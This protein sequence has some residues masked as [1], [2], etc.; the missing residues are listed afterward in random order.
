M[1]W[2][3]TPAPC[4]GST[5]YAGWMK[6]EVYSRHNDCR[7][8]VPIASWSCWRIANGRVTATWLMCPQHMEMAKRDDVEFAD[9]DRRDGRTHVYLPLIVPAL[10]PDGTLDPHSESNTAVEC[11]LHRLLDLLYSAAR[12]TYEQ[13]RVA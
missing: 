6:C 2:T 5:V 10:L 7:Q 4:D 13:R 12:W 9:E 8:Y 1:M 11:F 3:E